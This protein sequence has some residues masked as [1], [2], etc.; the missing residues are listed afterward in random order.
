MCVTGHEA[1]ADRSPDPENEFKTHA[2]WVEDY[3]WLFNLWV[4]HNVEK[5]YTVQRISDEYIC[6]H[7]YQGS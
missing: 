7:I 2:L 6:V 4:Y 5:F 1:G 3:L